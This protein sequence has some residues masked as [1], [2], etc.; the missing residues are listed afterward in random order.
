MW[1]RGQP[2]L[3]KPPPTQLNEEE[4]MALHRGRVWETSRVRDGEEGGNCP[5]SSEHPSAAHRDNAVFLCRQTR[6]P[7]CR[8]F[9]FLH[10]KLCGV[11]VG[12]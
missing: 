11:G 5:V 7:T 10:R 9:H 3:Q 12:R 6:S 8:F 1:E 2:C 4:M